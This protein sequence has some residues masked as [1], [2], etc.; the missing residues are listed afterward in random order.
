[1]SRALD[2]VADPLHLVAPKTRLRNVASTPMKSLASRDVVML[3][4]PPFCPLQ[5]FNPGATLLWS[6]RLS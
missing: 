2:E 1:M 5:Q 3:H 6:R 4:D